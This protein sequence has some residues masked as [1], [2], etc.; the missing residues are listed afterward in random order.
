MEVNKDNYKNYIKSENNVVRAVVARNGFGLE[1]LVNDPA[2]IVRVAVAEQ[3]Y[4]L[5]K[6]VNDKEYLVRAEVAGQGY[7]HKKLIH[8]ENETV[9]E[10]VVL[11]SDGFP[12]YLLE[13]LNDESIYVRT[14]IAKKFLKELFTD[15]NKE[16]QGNMAKLPSKIID[17]IK[18]D[19]V[20][21]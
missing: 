1:E 2:L 20:V 12:P 17:A 5:D 9:R 16:V 8:D 15:E 4:G 14:S 10:A 6:L 11:H 18:N 21:H 3:G 7:G 13:L 19:K